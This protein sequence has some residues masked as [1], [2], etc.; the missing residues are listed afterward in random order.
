MGE[1]FTD[2]ARQIGAR[3]LD[4]SPGETDDYLRFYS[5]RTQVGSWARPVLDKTE[6][7]DVF[8][9]RGDLF[10]RWRWG[11]LMNLQ[12]TVL[13]RAGAAAVGPFDVSYPIA[14]DFGY[15]AKACRLYTA[16]MISAPSCIKHEYAAPG[17]PLAEDHLVT[18]KTAL[19]FARDL[20]RW[21][22]ELFG[23][24]QPDDPEIAR[25]RALFQLYVARTALSAGCTGEAAAHLVQAAPF[26]PPLT[27]RPL[28]YLSKAMP[29]GA[30]A[31]GAYSI[32][33]RARA[34]PARV[35]RKLRSLLAD[36]RA[37]TAQR[38]A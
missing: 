6:Y 26:L 38:R 36:A 1:W 28:L 7:R 11:F 9:Y 33:T 16:N 15:L 23:N 3:S 12:A 17:R 13:T 35:R 29:E 37:R 25:L 19:Q 8:L 31:R 22:D 20:L 24:D 27:A 2:L 21:H 10:S 32:A 18:G 5:S 30:A 4:L 14:S 34:L